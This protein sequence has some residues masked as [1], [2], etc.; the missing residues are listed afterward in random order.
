MKIL[1]IGQQG[2]V[3]YALNR[4]LQPLG[5][6]IAVDRTQLDLSDN[7]AIQRIVQNIQPQL[8]VNAAAYT[9]VDRAEQEPELAHQ[10][11]AT[12]PGLLAALAHQVG[13]VLVHYSTDYVFDGSQR[14]PYQESDPTCPLGV[15]GRTKLAGEQAI[16]SSGCTYLILRTS[17]V[18]GLRGK[19]FLLTMLRLGK[20]REE[21]RVVQDQQGIPTPSGLIAEQTALILAQAGGDPLGF[22]RTKG[23]IYNLTCTGATTWYDFTRAIFAHTPDPSRKL[24]TVTPI[25]TDQYPTPAARPAYSVLA[26]DKIRSTFGLTLPTWEEAL[27]ACLE[28]PVHGA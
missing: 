5:E 9:A 17:W 7:N 3:G 28:T 25:T 6:V 13:A 12:A 22:F 1:L 18:Y 23:G 19:N 8:I 24:K 2:Q 15:Y 16:Q 20:E 21:L 11:N 10:I 4:S 14:T 27:V 26:T